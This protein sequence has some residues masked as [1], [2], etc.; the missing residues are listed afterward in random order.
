VRREAKGERVNTTFESH[1]DG[2]VVMYVSLHGPNTDAAMHV[3]Q[4][5]GCSPVTLDNPN[6]P[7]LFPHLGRTYRIRIAVPVEEAE[8]AA[9]AL[10]EWQHENA[11]RQKK[12]QA[13]MGAWFL[14]LIVVVTLAS[15][16]P[17]LILVIVSLMENEVSSATWFWCI[18]VWILGCAILLTGAR[19]RDKQ[20]SG[21]PAWWVPAAWLVGLLF[22]IGIRQEGGPWPYDEES[23]RR[24][25]PPE[26]LRARTAPEEEEE[27][28][29]VESP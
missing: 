23:S 24:H 25:P 12:F 2:L 20:S 18:M 16:V 21:R 10:L 22:G 27:A 7:N 11:A 1:R 19:R 15:I 29:P 3:L 28:D 13:D 5:A 6:G 14:R 9:G 8:L 17:L 26:D 4:K